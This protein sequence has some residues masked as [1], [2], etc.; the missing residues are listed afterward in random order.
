MGQ[1]TKIEWCDHSWSPWR[2]CTKVSPGCANCYAETLSKRNPAVLGQ[3]GKG[4]PRVLAKNWHEPVRWNKAAAEDLRCLVC[5]ATTFDGQVN[6]DGYCS[7]CELD[8]HPHHQTVFPSLCDWLDDE[9]PVEWL[10]KFLQLIHATP[11]IIWMT[12]T[13]RPENWKARMMAV[14]HAIPDNEDEESLPEWID[15]LQDW[16]CSD[17]PPANVWV[18]TSVEDQIRADERIPEL[19]RI[20]AAGLFLS[21]EPLLGDVRLNC[22]KC[23]T[24]ESEGGMTLF[25]NALNGFQATSG[26]SGVTGPKVDWVIIGGES[27]PGA[28]PCNVEWIRSLVRQCLVSKAPV[29]VKQLGGNVEQDWGGAAIHPPMFSVKLKHP[30]GGDPAEWPEDLRVREFPEGLR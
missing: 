20:P 5:G 10:A 12:L 6:T 23:G 9:V 15:W 30:K 8:A 27:G 3:W 17:T 28:R 4:K 18:G 13:K 16:V 29:F 26:Y 1:L 11:N 2:G 7:K 25:G 19:L 24:T 21:L 22:Y 14:L